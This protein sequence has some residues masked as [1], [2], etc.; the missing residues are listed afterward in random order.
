MEL[1][2][3][4]PKQIFLTLSSIIVT[5]GGI[6]FQGLPLESDRS[7][8]DITA[9]SNYSSVVLQNVTADRAAIFRFY[10]DYHVV[11]KDCTLNEGLNLQ[12]TQSLLIANSSF[13]GFHTTITIAPAFDHPTSHV[14]L[15]NSSFTKTSCGNYVVLLITSAS[16][17][18]QAAEVGLRNL[19]FEDNNCTT[20]ITTFPPAIT[21][22]LSLSNVTMDGVHFSN[23]RGTP[24]LL[25]DSTIHVFGENTFIGNRAPQGG[26][27]RFINSFLVLHK[28]IAYWFFKTITRMTLVEPGM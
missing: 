13:S 15:V 18:T 12:T 7:T 5:N 27:M 9:S 10:S 26:G 20:L 22:L 6:I 28:K 3:A 25:S 1:S 11:T 24:L 4:Q 17:D 19:T 2:K 21:I 23:N 14:T 8:T 16:P